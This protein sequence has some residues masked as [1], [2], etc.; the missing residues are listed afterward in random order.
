M[1]TSLSQQLANAHGRQ[2]L[3]AL[4]FAGP[5][6]WDRR[7]RP[8]GTGRAP[9]G[10]RLGGAVADLCDG[11]AGDAAGRAAVVATGPG[12][13]ACRGHQQQW[14]DTGQGIGRLG[15]VYGLYGMGYILPATFLSQMANQQFQGQWMADLFW[16]A[17]GLAAAL[18][19]VW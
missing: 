7:D 12:A 14:P 18:G 17:F 8:A 19:V 3:G 10:A 2:R 6:A 13:C 15:L 5:G 11:C 16:P 4:V 1:I 9:A